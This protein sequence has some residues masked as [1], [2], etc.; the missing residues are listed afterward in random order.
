MTIYIFNPEHDIALASNL[1][2]FTAPHAGRELRHDLGFLPALWAG[3]G[4]LVLVDDVGAAREALH[5][6]GLATDAVIVD[7]QTLGGMLRH[8]D[9]QPEIVPWGWDVALRQSLK[10]AGIGVGSLPSNA[11]LNVI[12]QLSHR[13]WASEHLLKPLLGVEGTVGRAEVLPDTAA[14][15]A[16]LSRCHDI[17]LKAPWSSSGRGIRYV[18]DVEALG[19]GEPHGLTPHLEGWVRNIVNRQGCVMGEPYYNKVLDFGMEFESDGDGAV[20]YRG[21]SLFDTVN[22]AYAGNVIDDEGSKLSFLSRYLP[23][24]LV[25]TVRARAVEL[26][27]EAFAGIYAG[28]FGIDM[29]V[30]RA[31]R[32]LALHPCVELNLRM[33]MGH[34]ALLLGRSLGLERHV[35]RIVYSN[36]RYNLKIA[37][38][39]VGHEAQ[40]PYFGE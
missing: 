32:S 27:S 8:N 38:P 26:L 35:M 37:P 6:L 21:L 12:R 20:T 33:T 22:G 28:P 30:V 17:V 9:L 36:G 24:S 39:F 29:M 34:V 1:E 4:S 11:R 40:S 16:Y 23:L 13:A 19:G 15:R 25:N 14:V 2:H 5:R 10:G 18:S 31:A 7:A 3:R